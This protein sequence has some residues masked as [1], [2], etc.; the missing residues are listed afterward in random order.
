MIR[1]LIVVY[2]VFI[3][4]LSPAQTSTNVLSP[5][6]SV[7]GY[8]QV[9]S[10]GN[11]QLKAGDFQAAHDAAMKA[12]SLDGNRF[13]A[14]ALEALA[15]YKEG[16]TDQAK[17]FIE[18]ALAKAPDSKKAQLQTMAAT[19][20]G[21][22]SVAP[23]TN[24]VQAMTPPVA[25]EREQLNADDR[26]EY[27]TLLSM[28][29]AADKATDLE[30]RHKILG[31]F[32][33]KSSLLLKYHPD[34]VRLWVARAAVALE[35]NR[36]HEGWLVATKLAALGVLN[37]DD[38]AIRKVIVALNQR[39]WLCKDDPYQGPKEGQNWTVPGINLEMIWVSP[40]TFTM[41][42]PS[43]ETH[44]RT[45]ETQH[46][47]TLTKG[48]WLGKYVVTIS[49]WQ[50]VMGNNPTLVNNV[51]A[52]HGRDP[53]HDP[54]YAFGSTEV[55]WNNAMEFCRRLTQQADFT[56]LLPKG[57][58]YILP[59]EAQWEYACRAGTTGPY[60]VSGSFG[61]IGWDY[62]NSGFANIYVHPIGEKQPNAWGFY[63][64]HGNV[65]EWCYDWYGSYPDGDSIDPLGPTSGSYHVLRGGCVSYSGK[66]CRSASRDYGETLNNNPNQIFG[67][68]GGNE[69]DP[70]LGCRLALAPALNQN[71]D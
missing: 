55:S 19:I 6:T 65:S 60:N 43:N 47:V 30:Q 42:S 40:G 64:M 69:K 11:R 9:I 24:T 22:A 50:K 13:E 28:L 26:L 48:Y 70:M 56:G 23:P 14:Y 45:D 16:K 61:H 1:L 46:T 51:L 32:L 54:V 37:S 34:L 41:G 53:D 3:T 63:D 38:P 15:L 33:E 31:D 25:P 66:N 59:T 67:R 58:V 29:G 2:L 62:G 5:V 52:D 17:G 71:G 68:D 36:A 7:P 8:D 39:G 27:D 49:Q 4:T 57:Y 10:Q 21:S 20:E 18:I 12:L 35:L 44:R